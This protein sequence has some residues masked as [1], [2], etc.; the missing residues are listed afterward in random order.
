MRGRDR[1]TSSTKLEGKNVKVGKR[2]SR[3]QRGARFYSQ[4]GMRP[5]HELAKHFHIELK[6]LECKTPVKFAVLWQRDATAGGRQYERSKKKKKKKAMN[7]GFK[8]YPRIRESS[9]PIY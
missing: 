5:D 7:S 8:Q 3:R 9:I 4:Q 6:V 1:E 2:G